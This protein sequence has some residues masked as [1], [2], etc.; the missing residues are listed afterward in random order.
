MLY[1]S[2]LEYSLFNSQPWRYAVS[3]GSN[4]YN[5][6]SSHLLSVCLIPGVVLAVLLFIFLFNLLQQLCKIRTI[7]SFVGKL[8]FNNMLKIAH[9]L[10]GGIG[11]QI[12][13]CDSKPIL[14][15]GIGLCHL[16]MIVLI[17][18]PVRSQVTKSGEQFVSSYRGK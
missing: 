17:W 18:D 1:S 3:G 4:N 15:P 9:L 14:I 16:V 10:S 11:I 5:S 8:E 2:P 13:T 12:Q 7:F 6:T